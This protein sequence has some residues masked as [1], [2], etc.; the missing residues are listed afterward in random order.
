MDFLFR[1][2]PFAVGL[3]LRIAV[4]IQVKL[5][6]DEVAFTCGVGAVTSMVQA[7]LLL[8]TTTLFALVVFKLNLA[9]LGAVARLL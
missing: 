8:L 4:L 1:V 3:T 2:F 7:K 9:F 6:F 5:L